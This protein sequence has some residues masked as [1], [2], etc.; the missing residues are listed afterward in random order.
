MTK[1]GVHYDY[2]R[3]NSRTYKIKTLKPW[4]TLYTPIKEKPQRFL[5]NNERRVSLETTKR[6]KKEYLQKHSAEDNGFP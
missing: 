6:K 1:F 5:K 4:M 2:Y 3:F